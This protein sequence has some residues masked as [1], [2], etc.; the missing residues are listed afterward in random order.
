M[1]TARSVVTTSRDYL[2]QAE[3][4][5]D[6]GPQGHGARGVVLG[7]PQEQRQPLVL[8][9]QS[10]RRRAADATLGEPRLIGRVR[11]S[12]HRAEFAEHHA[13]GSSLDV[14]APRPHQTHQHA[15]SKDRLVGGER[16][17]YAHAGF[18][19]VQQVKINVAAQGRRPRDVRPEVDG[20][21][22]YRPSQALS[23]VDA[24]GFGPGRRV[25]RQTQI[26]VQT[27]DLLDDVGASRDTA[28]HVGA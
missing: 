17:G 9:R 3:A 26:T 6:R 24:S 2:V 18:T 27:S 12:E 13:A 7:A 1:K 28:A 10:Q 8:P 20:D 5:R 11:V 16:I 21:V 14:L 15:G 23:R 19:G 4:F 22:L 25:T